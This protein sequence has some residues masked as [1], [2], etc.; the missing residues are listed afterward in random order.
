MKNLNGTIVIV[1]VL[2]LVAG[3]AHQGGGSRESRPVPAVN[4]ESDC[5]HRDSRKREYRNP[6]LRTRNIGTASCDSG[7]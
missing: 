3:C 4:G 6:F 2:A 7:A 5:L 1:A